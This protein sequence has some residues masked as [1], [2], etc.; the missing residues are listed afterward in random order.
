M[1]GERFPSI[2]R[3]FTLPR[4]GQPNFIS[5]SFS[6][7]RS[8]RNRNFITRNSRRVNQLTGRVFP[9]SVSRFSSTEESTFLS[10]RT[11]NSESTVA[12]TEKGSPYLWEQGKA[13][14]LLLNECM[15]DEV[16]AQNIAQQGPDEPRQGEV[17]LTN[18][19]KKI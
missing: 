11:S 15:E 14:F 3:D 1:T 8:P 16:Q 7:R 9:R 5:F 2:I 12:S 19:F 4:A 17:Q 6:D 10:V 13:S 18:G